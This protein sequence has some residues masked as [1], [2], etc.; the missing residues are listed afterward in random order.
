MRKVN[1]YDPFEF[2]EPI[3]ATGRIILN[4]GDFYIL[5]SKEKVS[6]PPDLAGVM[7]AIDPAM[8]E[9]R[10]HYAGFFDPGFGYGLEH[11]KGTR[12]VLEVRSHD[13]PFV[14]EDGQMVG[15][16]EYER[17]LEPPDKIYGAGIGSSY[18][19]Q[20]LSLSKQFKKAVTSEK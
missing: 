7:T 3:P 20:G 4:P 5:I 1:Y 10:I 12:A 19:A 17:L 18:Q 14:L 6:I 2:W 11:G 16:L 13:M 9:F 8:G 15:R